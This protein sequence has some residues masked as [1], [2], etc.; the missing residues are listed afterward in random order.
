MGTAESAKAEATAIAVDAAVR[1]SRPDN[2]RGHAPR[3]MV[4]KKAMYDILGN[5]A[6]VERLFLIVKEQKEY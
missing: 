3:E 6:A 5:E 1:V 2:W 4:I